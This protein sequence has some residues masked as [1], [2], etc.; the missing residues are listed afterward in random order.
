MTHLLLF[1]LKDASKGTYGDPE[2]I[3]LTAED[4]ENHSK[5]IQ[6]CPVVR[7][8]KYRFVRMM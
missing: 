3:E 2:T 6:T 8:I 1:P 4:I 5:T 7:V